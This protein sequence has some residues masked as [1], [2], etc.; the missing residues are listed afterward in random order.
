M[1]SKQQIRNNARVYLLPAA[2]L[3]SLAACDSGTSLPGSSGSSTPT[4]DP[5]ILPSGSATGV[6][7]GS[8]P[9]SGVSYAASSGKSGVTNEAGHF[10]FTYGDTIEFKIGKLSLGN[11]PATDIITPITLAEESENKLSN[12]ITL[13]QSLD[14]DGDPSNGIS[15]SDD[16]AA[17]LSGSINLQGSPDTFAN[18]A[19]LQDALE[20]GGIDGEV[21]TPEE[22][23]ERFLAQGFVSL[24]AYTWATHDGS[25]A[26]MLRVAQ[27]GSGKYLHGSARP[28]DSCDENR[29]C[30]GRV[31]YKAGAEIGIGNA[32]E[33]D[34]RGFIL[35]GEPIIDTNLRD[36]LS[37]PAATR[38][39][40]TDGLALIYSD[41]V[42][43]PLER[44][45]KGV[46]AE[47]FHIGGASSTVSAKRGAVAETVIV[48]TRLRRVENDP[49]GIVGAWAY[50]QDTINTRT[51]IFFPD[52][53]LFLVDPTGE[54]Q[55]EEQKECANPGVEF[56]NYTYNKGA[57]SLNI[58]GFT[59]N[60]DGCIGLSSLE[61]NEAH[62]FTISSD[63]DSA[64]LE[65]HGEEPVTVYRISG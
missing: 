43:L 7:L 45:Q 23:N 41:I 49:T 36:G 32:T 38:R 61:S 12:L 35:L 19:K 6:L 44:E 64:I 31:I 37:Y 17:A 18:S 3:F 16:T 46:F 26:S 58:S 1:K 56:A 60:T 62:K 9:V 10:D 5:I 40:R 42:A 21:K 47:V 28:D 13:L 2:L 29:V 65:K 63:G 24:D 14:A 39:V 25:V 22:A 15:I 57:N 8:T 52:G 27:D 54:T 20:A 53:K 48:D 4:S 50:D 34:A 59:Y 51:A 55:V 11:V 33:V 30:R